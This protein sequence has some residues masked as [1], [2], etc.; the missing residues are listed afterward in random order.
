MKRRHHIHRYYPKLQSELT[1]R[2][3]L[4]I[5]RTHLAN[6]RTLL[7][8]FRTALYL[9]LAGMTIMTLDILEE[10]KWS[11][12]VLYVIAAGVFIYG[13]VSYRI[14]DKKLRATEASAPAPKSRKKRR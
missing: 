5:D 7:A 3:R 10:V 6:R 11:S 1:L 2:D 8:M 14:T 9:V 4:A 12:Y 13:W